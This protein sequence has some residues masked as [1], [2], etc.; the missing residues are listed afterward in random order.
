MTTQAKSNLSKLPDMCA[1]R[2][3]TDDQ[4]ILI[5]AGES[6][7]HPMPGVDVDAFNARHSVTPAQVQAMLA[8]SMFGWDCPGANP[9]HDAN[10]AA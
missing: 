6:G 10:R 2:N 8:G 7:Y 5:V 4:A 1:A 9:D 3:P